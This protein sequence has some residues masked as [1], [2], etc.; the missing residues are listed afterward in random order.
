MGKPT[1]IEA[2]RNAIIDAQGGWTG[3]D[4]PALLSIWGGPSSCSTVSLDGK[5]AAECSERASFYEGWIER[6]DAIDAIH[7]D[8]KRDEAA[9][10]LPGDIVTPRRRVVGWYPRTVEE[11]C[12]AEFTDGALGDQARR[13]TKTWRRGERECVRAEEAAEKAEEAGWRALSSLDDAEA[14]LTSAG[15]VA[16]LEYA[17]LELADAASEEREYGDDPTWGPAWRLAAEL[18]EGLDDEDE[19]DN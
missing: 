9:D 4:W 11:P 6:L 10:D 7:D 1:E 18:V 8:D 19:D 14:A 2:V 15:R 5:T 17:A 12:G 13:M 16:G 3:H